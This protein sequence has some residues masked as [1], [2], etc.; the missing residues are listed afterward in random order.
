LTVEFNLSGRTALVTGASSGFGRHFAK[1]LAGAGASVILAARRE[2]MLEDVVTE[3]EAEGGSA[4]AIRL[5]VSRDEDVRAAFEDMPVLDIVVNNA[6]VGGM[7]RS[8]E[9]EHA[10]W[11][12]IYDV[13]VHGAWSVAQHAARAM[14]AAGRGGS[15]INIASITGARPGYNT[16]AYS[17]SKAAVTHMTRSLAAEWARHNIRVNAIAPGYFLTEMTTGLD[18]T[19]YGKAMMQRIPQGRFG[20]LPDLDGPLLLLASDL[21]RYMTGSVVVVDGGHVCSPL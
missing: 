10:D 15:I 13:N 9:F 19:N 18:D 1:V 6:G 2:A 4:R 5:D 17:S 11:R 16:A 7:G 14:V 12:N 21:S 8:L 20:D 3:I